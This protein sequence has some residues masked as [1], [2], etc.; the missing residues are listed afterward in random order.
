[1]HIE[2]GDGKVTLYFERSPNQQA[3]AGFH[4][5]LMG[6]LVCAL[7]FGA[8]YRLV[9]VPPSQSLPIALFF[10]AC[11]ALAAWNG[12]TSLFESDYATVFDLRARTVILRESGV[13]TRQHGPVSFD[14][15]IGVRTRVGF[16]LN[17]RSV[18]AELMLA[19]G[20]EWRLG[21]ELIWLRPVSSSDIPD[22]IARLRKATGLPG[23]DSD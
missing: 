23:C 6:A 19:S 16:A 9:H 10:I 21:Y 22:V 18:I 11:A 20:E 1:M 5:L 8:I 15:I 7:L 12:S 4:A 14:Q 2:R 13:M 3:M 17:H